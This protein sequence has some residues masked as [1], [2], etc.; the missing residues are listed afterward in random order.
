ME[1]FRKAFGAHKIICRQNYGQSISSFQFLSFRSLNKYKSKNKRRPFSLPKSPITYEFGY[2]E[3]LQNRIPMLKSVEE[4]YF[5]M[6]YQV[7]SP[8]YTRVRIK[9]NLG[10]QELG[11]LWS[12]TY[13]KRSNECCERPVWT[14]SR[15]KTDLNTGIIHE[16]NKRTVR[17]VT[18][19]PARCRPWS[20]KLP[21]SRNCE[22]DCCERKP[23]V[24]FPGT[25]SALWWL[26]RTLVF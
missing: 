20:M 23:L 7:P 2:P 15:T 24:F 3:K 25:D 4:A 13:T 22:L 19:T 5:L 9:L 12:K 10:D 18:F 1:L 21:T 14:L 11:F 8:S 6:H 17:L 16:L 26:V